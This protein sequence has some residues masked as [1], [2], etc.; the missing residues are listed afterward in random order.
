M[1]RATAAAV[2]AGSAAEDLRHRPV[3]IAA[4]PDYVAVIAVGG[5][6]QVLVAQ[7]FQYGGAGRLLADINVVVAGEVAVLV[8][9]DHRLFEMAD[10]QHAVEDRQTDLAIEG[11]LVSSQILGRAPSRRRLALDFRRQAAS[12]IRVFY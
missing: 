2:E 4:A 6:D 5:A 12:T 10:H 8:E 3:G 1:Q 7:R 9:P 11:H